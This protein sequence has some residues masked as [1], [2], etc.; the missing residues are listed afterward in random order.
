MSARLAK[1]EETVFFQA[2]GFRPEILY[3]EDFS[4][5]ETTE[6]SEKKSVMS[7]EDYHIIGMKKVGLLLVSVK[8]KKE[9]GTS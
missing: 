3:L 7:L 9:K 5:E 6:V 2:L 8:V 4:Q 1:I